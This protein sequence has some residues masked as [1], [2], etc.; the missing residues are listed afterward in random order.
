MPTL[1][2]KDAAGKAVARDV[3]HTAGA[4]A[5]VRLVAEQ[6]TLTP[7]F[8]RVGFVRV[9]VVDARGVLVPGAAVPLTVRVTG[10]GTLA[11]F[12]N[13]DPADTTPFASAVRKAWNG[14]AL[15]M[16]RATGTSGAIIVEVTGEGLRPARVTLR[17]T[18]P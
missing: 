18:A 9:E 16:V 17:A 2:K 11:A 6:T 1:E 7:G 4:P 13:G 10:A 12:D 14:R 5:A 15:A 3:L 8:D